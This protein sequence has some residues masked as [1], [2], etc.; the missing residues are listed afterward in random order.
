MN[1]W[2]RRALAATLVFVLFSACKRREAPHEHAS[3]HP[4]GH[5]HHEKNHGHGDEAVVRITRWS[6]RLEAFIE[7]AP[8]VQG[9]DVE[10]LVHLTVLDGFR[11]P[12]R[13]TVRL[14]LAGPAPLTAEA[15]TATHPG[16]FPLSLK[17]PQPGTYR[18]RLVVTGGVTDTI[19]GLAVEVFANEEAARAAAPKE[20]EGSFIEFLKEQQ[21]GVPFATA[22]V[23]RGTLVP[24]IE[25]SGT[26]GTP[27]GGNAE[28]GA[29]LAGRLVP[30]ARGL[31]KPGELVKK[32]QI[33]ATLAPAPA[34][35]EEAARSTLAV[36][37]ASARVEQANAAL[38]RA[39]RLLKDQAIAARELEDAQRERGVAEDALR[40]AKRAQ[41]VFSGAAAGSGAG[42]W[43]LV[44]PM[45]GTLVDVRATP[46][47]TVSQGTVLFRVVDT[48]ELW[49][50]ARVP[51]Q[52]AAR[53]RADRDA[54]FQIPGLDD[55]LPIRVSEA[56]AGADGGAP[57]GL[58]TIGRMVDPG[59]RT[60]DV[61]Y[62]LST[63]DPR[64]RVGGLVRVNVPAGPDFA[65]I[66]I[67]RSAVIDDDG[68]DVVYVQVDGEHFERRSVRLGPRQGGSVGVLHGLS[69]NE[70]IVTRGGNVVRLAARS[71]SGEPH[72][73]IH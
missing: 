19:D 46:G 32:G 39:E 65:G 36:A 68:R 13:A 59:S 22:F 5:D 52:D 67:A 44:S 54:A 38:E 48:G 35:P 34:S 2:R 42:S 26:V 61:I 28:V 72:G 27:P 16:V 40:S 71:G 63:P 62:S 31:P 4:A 15:T 57:G 21:W 37:E 17:A 24:S 50:R 33:L 56:D 6:E 10:F 60:V 45:A 66:V 49:I 43:Q 73:H 8:A 51:E 20:E 53:L 25:V 12:E 47:A 55:F 29:P 69:E 18:G 30:P 41:Q 14:E 1:F 64:L 11:T 9:K 3:D 58:V 7:H 70:R 23:G